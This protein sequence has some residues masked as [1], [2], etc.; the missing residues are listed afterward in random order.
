M[1]RRFLNNGDYAGLIT[2]VALS[3]M[4]RDDEENLLNAEEAAEFSVVEYLTENYE[5]EKVLEVGRKILPY[6][7][8]ITYTVG[9]H[10]INKDEKG[11]FCVY[12]ALRTIN[13]S[14]AP[15]TSSYWI[16][17]NGVDDEES[18]PRYSQIETYFQG[19]VVKFANAYFKCVEPNGYDFGDIRVPGSNGWEEVDSSCWMANIEY[20]LWN[21]VQH[22]GDFYALI[23]LDNIDLTVN[24]AESNNWG[25][26]GDYDPDYNAYEFSPTE[27]VVYGGKVF[28]PVMNVNSDEI[29]DGYNIRKHDP[30]NPNVK[31][32]ML[33]L[34]VYELTKMI[35][36]NNVSSARIT[37]Y[38]NSIKWLGDASRLRINPQIPRKLDE[39]QQPETDYAIATFA[40]DYDP[41]DNPWQ[42]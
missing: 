32:H 16:E 27:Y 30:R 17:V 11:R 35:S 4:T 37:D 26:I 1:Y 15:A 41:N 7:R 38:E 5:I 18:V 12:E 25:L 23:S 6:N 8:Q 28:A 36:P 40:R 9:S 33:R 42:I 29:K 2:K 24:P 21:V 19:D 13:G 39:K 3:Q 10:F 14:K 22:E 34:A 20:E 31:K